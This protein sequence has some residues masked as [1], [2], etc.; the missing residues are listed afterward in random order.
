MY[1]FSVAMIITLLFKENMKTSVY[2]IFHPIIKVLQF[3]LGSTMPTLKAEIFNQ[4][5]F[6]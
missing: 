3:K 5:P 6:F 4:L 2:K 1:P